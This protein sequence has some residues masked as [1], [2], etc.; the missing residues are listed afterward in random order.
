MIEPIGGYLDT[1]TNNEDFAITLY[2]SGFWARR[3]TIIMVGLGITWGWWS[4]FLGLGFDLPKRIKRFR[5][6]NKQRKSD[7]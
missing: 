6:I 2:V 3:G 5:V 7:V 1:R 4:L